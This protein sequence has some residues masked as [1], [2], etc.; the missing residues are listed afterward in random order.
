[1]HAM[2]VFNNPELRLPIYLY[3][4][5]PTKDET[6]FILVVSLNSWFHSTVNLFVLCQFIEFKEFQVVFTV[7]SYLWV[8]LYKVVISV[9]WL[10]VRS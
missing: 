9:R 2:N 7:S 10:F 4:G 6:I 8:T 5:L 3:T 1:M